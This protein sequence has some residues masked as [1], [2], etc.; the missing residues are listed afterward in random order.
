MRLGV[1][2][3]GVDAQ[4]VRRARERPGGPRARSAAI[5][6][7]ARGERILLGI[8]R[9]DYTKGIPRRLLA[10]ERLLEREPR[11]RGKVRLVQV[12]V[13]SRDKVPSY[14]EFRRQVDELVGRI[15]GAF[16]T[17]DWVPIH[18]VHRSLDRAS[19]WSR[20]IAPRT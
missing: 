19:T 9:L 7:E 13:P 6:A 1:F 3:I 2:P 14:Q 15:N 10:F 17:V 16:S 12:A 5:R 20:S 18:Y 8:D 11:W 4:D